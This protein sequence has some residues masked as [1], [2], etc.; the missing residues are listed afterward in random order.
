VHA[1]QAKALHQ[2]AEQSGR[3]R[4]DHQ[5]GPEAYPFRYLVAEVRADH[6]EARVGEIKTPII[7][8]MSVSPEASMNSSS[9]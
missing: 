7:E 9:P 1:P 4:C 8:K 3:N 2:G 5:C 6:V